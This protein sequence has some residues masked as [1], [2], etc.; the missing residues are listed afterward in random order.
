MFRSEIQMKEID[1]WGD[2]RFNTFANTRIACRGIIINNEQ[3]LVTR[4]ENT[5]FWLIPGGGLELEESLEECCAR[6]ILE[7][8]GYIVGPLNEFL[9]VNEYYGDYKFISHYFECEVV[10]EGKQKLTDAEQ[11]NGLV[12]KWIDL[13]EFLCIL[14]KHQDY[15]AINEEKRGAYLREYTALSEYLKSKS[16]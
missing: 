9:I 15:V 4:E 13:Q 8:T 5:D 16:R 2:N 11:A 3:I 6:E 10:G 12:P 7:E 14:G 1:I